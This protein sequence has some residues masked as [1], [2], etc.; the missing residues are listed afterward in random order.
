MHVVQCRI[1]E[2]RTR[3]DPQTSQAASKLHSLIRQ[4]CL[5]L[6]PPA[7]EPNIPA[8]FEEAQ[9]HDVF[10]CGEFAA[11]SFDEAGSLSRLRV[12]VQ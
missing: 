12:R 2:T 9:A 6:Q 3:T 5:E 11:L 8:G 4:G 10:K 7:L 1:N